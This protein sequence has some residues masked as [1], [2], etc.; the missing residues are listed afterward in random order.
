MTP[1]D[2]Q[3]HVVDMLARLDTKM[4]D[5]IGNGKP[6]RVAKL[7][8]EVKSINKWR[9]MIFGIVVALSAIIHFIFKY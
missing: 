6:G 8:D 2:F 5:L 3:T 7:E 1:E 9:W 4:E